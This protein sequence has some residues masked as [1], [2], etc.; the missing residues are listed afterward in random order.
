MLHLGSRI[1]RVYAHDDSTARHTATTADDL[2]S[3]DWRVAKNSARGR[4]LVDL[5]LHDSLFDG[6]LMLIL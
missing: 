1:L 6:S 4:A 2:A 5:F 3:V